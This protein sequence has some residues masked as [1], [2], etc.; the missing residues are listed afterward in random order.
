MGLPAEYIAGIVIAVVLLATLVT[1]IVLATSSLRQTPF[2]PVVFDLTTG[3]VFVDVIASSRRLRSVLSAS[4]PVSYFSTTQCPTCVFQ[5][6]SPKLSGDYASLNISD[7]VTFG[8]QGV[9][10][11]VV[12]TDT[13]TIQQNTSQT[14]CG[15]NSESLKPALALV[16]DQFLLIA[17]ESVTGGAPANQVGISPL[18]F[19]DSSTATGKAVHSVLKARKY[20]S[21]ILQNLYASG[22]SVEWTLLLKPFGSQLWLGGATPPSRD[23]CGTKGPLVYTPLLPGLPLAASPFFSDPGRYYAIG[24]TSVTRLAPDGSREVVDGSS[25]PDAPMPKVAIITL[26]QPLIVVPQSSLGTRLMATS[27]TNL[28]GLELT[29]VGGAVL[30]VTPGRSMWSLGGTGLQPIYGALPLADTKNL[31]SA[32]DVILLGCLAF[33]NTLMHFDV[34]KGRFGLVALQADPL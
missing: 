18:Q 26:S 10:K 24:I 6:Y 34:A 30:T 2:I 7:T 17:A 31:S 1:V 22:D 13:L 16:L 32:N 3:A 29:F 28:Q 12:G 5:P 8:T 11:G 33:Q 4:S 9:V 21:S 14:V 25:Y 15:Y 23:M 20:E 19:A 27:P